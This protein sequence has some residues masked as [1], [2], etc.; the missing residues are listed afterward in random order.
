MTAPDSPAPDDPD[1]PDP[2]DIHH[3]T[4]RAD[5]ALQLLA[6]Y[7]SADAPTHGGR[8]LSYVYDSGL[9]VLDEVAA[10]A[11]RMVQSVNGL[12][13][14]VFGS[15]AAMERDLIEFGRGVFHAPDAVG[16]VTSGG[17]ESCL[18][19][20][21]AARDRAGATPGQASMVLPTTA[22]AAFLKAA[23]LFGVEAI[24]VPVPTPSTAVRA[25]DIAGAIRDDTIL[26]V[27]S[28]PN[29]P[30]GVLDPITE[31]AE[32]TS[33]HDLAFHVD[34]CLGGFALAWWDGLPPWDFR[35][36]G[37]TS[38]S[39]DLHKYGYAPKG[40]SILLHR[41]RDRHRAQFFSITRWPGYPIV[42]PTLLGSRSAV[43]LASAWAV[44]RTLGADG[45]AA[46]TARIRQAFDAVVAA[47][48]GIDGLCVVGAPSGPVLA[49]RT[50]PDADEPVDTNLWGA[51][52]TNRGFALQ[53]Q[54][55]FT[56]PDGTELPATTHLTITPV[57]EAVLD[58]LVPT[59]RSAADEVRGTPPPVAP[60]ALRELAAAFDSGAVTV[61]QALGLPSAAAEEVL[62]SAGIDPHRHGGAADLDMP[63]IIAA[64]ESL[65]REVTAR[66]LAEFLAAYCNP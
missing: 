54:P 33:S 62:V 13:P 46:L 66:L 2:V 34:A 51:A 22:H 4:E 15:V 50:D 18:L 9:A 56:Q 42:N 64:V 6:T 8:V 17:T 20:V 28:A 7:R 43:G 31:I 10:S 39:A 26:V 36:D 41:D 61:E 24:R 38:L 27:A 52:V 65:P 45:Y 55:A 3:L 53:A 23:E 48:D 1:T 14:T 25:D 32:V 16:S 57:T 35:V 19:A 29:Y 60:S 47:I 30:T 59:L 63:A 21:K 12:D 49:V 11:A 37:V 58:E 5:A 44:S 40:S